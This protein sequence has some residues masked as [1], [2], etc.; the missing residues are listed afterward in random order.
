MSVFWGVIV[1]NEQ[2]RHVGRQIELEDATK[3]GR[4]LL[5]LGL[6]EKG[7]A[8]AGRPWSAFAS[9]GTYPVIG[10]QAGSAHDDASEGLFGRVVLGI[11]CFSVVHG[12]MGPWAFFR[13]AK[14]LSGCAIV[15][16]ATRGLGMK[17]RQT[18]SGGRKTRL[19]GGKGGGPTKQIGQGNNGPP[20]IRRATNLVT[21][22]VSYVHYFKPSS[23]SSPKSA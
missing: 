4:L 17:S 20:R 12:C 14:S 22:L 10:R 1:A 19:A 11:G 16:L 5:Y 23:I 6:R 7:S 9:W 15:G 8:A 2:M 13:R 3:L 18:R 21:F